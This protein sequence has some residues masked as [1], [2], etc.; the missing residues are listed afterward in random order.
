MTIGDIEMDS[1]LRITMPYGVSSAIKARR[2][3]KC[4]SIKFTNNDEFE[5]LCENCRK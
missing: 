3:G 2:C 4:D 1:Y 5:F